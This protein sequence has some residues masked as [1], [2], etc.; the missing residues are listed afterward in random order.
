MDHLERRTPLRIGILALVV[1]AASTVIWFVSTNIGR[2]PEECRAWESAL[3]R[4]AASRNLRGGTAGRSEDEVS[5]DH[6]EWKRKL[7][8]YPFVVDPDG[9]RFDRPTGCSFE[10]IQDK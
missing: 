10:G 3:K 1:L 9:E 6:Q 7:A 8:A 5:G 2:N 4:E